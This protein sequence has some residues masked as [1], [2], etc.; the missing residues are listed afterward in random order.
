MRARD[1]V[2]ATAF[3]TKQQ[4]D[5]RHQM[6]MALILARTWGRRRMGDPLR[7]PRSLRY[8]GT[9]GCVRIHPHSSRLRDPPRSRLCRG[10]LGTRAHVAHH[11]VQSVSTSRDFV[12]PL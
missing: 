7:R 6:A 3:R 1:S 10:S 11:L 12:L 8:S 2:L 9:A 4:G 5:A